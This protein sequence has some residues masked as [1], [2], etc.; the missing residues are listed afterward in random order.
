MGAQNAPEELHDGSFGRLPH[1]CVGVF[2]VGH[3]LGHIG[4]ER[5][6]F[7]LVRLRAH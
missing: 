6:V 3:E 5:Q 7:R 4:A 2:E 1:A